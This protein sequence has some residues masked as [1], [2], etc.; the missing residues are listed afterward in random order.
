MCRYPERKVLF[1]DKMAQIFFGADCYLEFLYELKNIDKRIMYI[2]SED[3]NP[4]E[5]LPL[6]LSLIYSSVSVLHSLLWCNKVHE[7]PN[8]AREETVLL[9]DC[10]CPGSG[11]GEIMQH[12]VCYTMIAR[13]RGWIPYILL[14]NK[15]SNSYVLNDGDNMWEYYFD[16]VSSIKLDELDNF[17]RYISLCEN[18]M[19]LVSMDTNPY[20][21]EMFYIMHNQLTKKFVDNSFNGIV[22]IHKQIWERI[23]ALI[24]P[25]LFDEEIRILGVICRG[26]DQRKEVCEAKGYTWT[27][28]TENQEKI[29]KRIRS[30]KEV[31]QCQYIFVATE[32]SE[33]YCE[34][35]EAFGEQ[36]LVVDQKRISYSVDTKDY[37]SNILP[38]TKD[39][40]TRYLAVLYAL[41]KAKVLL[42]NIPCGAVG[43]AR[44][45]NGGCYEYVEV[46]GE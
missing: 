21:D 34:L 46:I 37:I 36:L 18:H 27:K 20:T 4:S 22:K 24:P 1:L 6:M 11:L 29:M 33:Y 32:D 10:P 3:V 30:L 35:K 17:K 44:L 26:T 40:V 7:N 8:A 2:T 13:D 5:R 23:N 41:S 43:V 42:A 19:P 14:N 16:N 28:G 38:N 45:F 39:F 12:C 31:W 25:L 15:D 9:I